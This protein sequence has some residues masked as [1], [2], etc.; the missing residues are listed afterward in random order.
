VVDADARL[1]LAVLFSAALHASLIFGVAVRRPS[2]A[3]ATEPILARI[4]AVS[5]TAARRPEPQPLDGHARRA[6]QPAPHPSAVAEPRWAPIDAAAELVRR[7]RQAAADALPPV[8]MPLLSDPTWYS[9]AQLDVFPVALAP[10]RPVHPQAAAGDT[11]GEVTLLLLIDESGRVHDSA[12]VDAQPPNTFEEAA[13][14]AF[15][16]ARFRPGERDGRSVRS[17]VLV[18][19]TFQPANADGTVSR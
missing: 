19:V 4:Q 13:L 15:R 16:A 14:E 17:R 12:V 5:D 3:P 8:E 6:A 9:A 18:R 11:G 2:T 1:A 7:A 10:V